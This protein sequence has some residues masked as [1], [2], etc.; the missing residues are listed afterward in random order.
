MCTAKGHVP[1]VLLQH[2]YYFFSNLLFVLS[3][4]GTGSRACK[5]SQEHLHRILHGKSWCLLVLTG[6]KKVS[7]SEGNKYI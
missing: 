3:S 5:P 1:V 4:G 6:A 7:E 2:F